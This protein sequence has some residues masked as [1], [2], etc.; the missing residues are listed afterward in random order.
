LFNSRRSKSSYDDFDAPAAVS[1]AVCV[2]DEVE[3][4]DVARV[5]AED[6]VAMNGFFAVPAV[7]V[8]EAGATN[9]QQESQIAS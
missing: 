4:V 9:K 2:E 1:E 7:A 6:G 5:L 3:A 8:V